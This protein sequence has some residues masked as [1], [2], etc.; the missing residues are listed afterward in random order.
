MQGR[1]W[2]RVLQ[3]QSPSAAADILFTKTLLLPKPVSRPGC[4]DLN[5]HACAAELT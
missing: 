5:E 2:Q 3:K 4:Y 1:D